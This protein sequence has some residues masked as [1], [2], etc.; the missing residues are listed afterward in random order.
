MFFHNKA[1]LALIT[2]PPAFVVMMFLFSLH[3]DQSTCTKCQ[4]GN[5]N[6]ASGKW[7]QWRL[8]ILEWSAAH[9]IVAIIGAVI[10]ILLLVASIIFFTIYRGH[11]VVQNNFSLLCIMQVDLLISFG[12]V[13]AFFGNPSSHTVHVWS[14]T[15]SLCVMHSGSSL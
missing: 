3:T 11:A 2:N 6:F 13:I 15:Y 10:G 5:Y 12:S 8:E 9:S 1:M 14:W 7:E 4:N